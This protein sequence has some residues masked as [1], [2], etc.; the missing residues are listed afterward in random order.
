[1]V[2]PDILIWVVGLIGV[3]F[4]V[5]LAN[6]LFLKKQQNYPDW[7]IKAF[8]KFERET[9][10]DKKLTDLEKI[11]KYFPDAKVTRDGD[12]TVIDLAGSSTEQTGRD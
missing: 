7:A 2:W 11:M 5:F 6:C 3:L 10:E 12:K 8:E 1:M 9:E 4:L